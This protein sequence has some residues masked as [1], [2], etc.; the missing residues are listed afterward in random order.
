MDGA[1][2]SVDLASLEA[3]RGSL[4]EAA[5]GIEALREHPGVVRARAADTGDP[6]LAAAAVDV[7]TSWEW[8]LELLGGELRR[9][10]ALLGVAASAYQDSDGSVLAALR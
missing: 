2:I 5:R 3:L 4:R 7:A 6:G 1:V 9:W 10:D 8:G